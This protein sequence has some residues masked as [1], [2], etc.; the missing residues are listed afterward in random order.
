MKQRGTVAEGRTWMHSRIAHWVFPALLFSLLLHCLFWLWANHVQVNRLSDAFYDRIVPRT[1]HLERVKIDPQLLDSKP[2]MEKHASPAAIKLPQEK[3]FLEKPIINAP[4]PPAATQ[5]DQTLLNEKPELAAPSL[6]DTLQT[7]HAAGAHPLAVDDQALVDQLLQEKAP[8]GKNPAIEL[9]KPT[10]TSG[11]ANGSM[12]DEVP[13]GFSNL[14]D[15]LAQTGPLTPE[16][17]PIFMPADL[18]YDYNS[19]ELRPAA[20]ANLEKLATLIRRNPS[21]C[22][23][24]EGH[25][26]S[27]G[28]EEFNLELSKKRAESVKNWLTNVMK[29]PSDSIQTIGF[30]KARLLI[31]ADKTIEEQQANRRVEIVILPAPDASHP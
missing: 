21:L 16:T 15:L 1:F 9:L 29:L 13:A 19:A 23:R 17:A 5:L 7:A 30:G 14:D 28:G 26:D 2:D 4:H 18:L 10:G 25:T 11:A 12:A 24:I 6:E 22:F 3:I 8:P 31:P 27:F 20:L